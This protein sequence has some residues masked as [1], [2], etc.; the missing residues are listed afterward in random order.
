MENQTV[1]S[2]FLLLG[3]STIPNVKY[4]LFAIFLISYI[5]TLA[6]NSMVI[7]TVL[8]SHQLHSP[9]YFFLCNLSLSEILFITNIIPKMLFVTLKE[10]DSVSVPEC[11][12]QLLIMSALTNTECS[13]LTVMS[14]DRFLAICKP[15]HYTSIMN[16]K[17]QLNLALWSWILSFIAT[18]CVV[19]QIYFLQFC[20]PSEFDHYYCDFAPI[21][22]HSCSD[23]SIL[24]MEAFL[25]SAPI[26]LFP[27]IFI[28]KVFSTCSSHMAVVSMY[29]GSLVAIYVVPSVGHIWNINKILSLLYTVVTPLLNPIIYSI[30]NQEIRMALAKFLFNRKFV[31]T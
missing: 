6:G 9:M 31:D 24:E 27:F 23:T 16:W 14:Y 29:Y 13:I 4:V 25:F 28:I 22:K 5:V 8:N 15:L 20:G 17:L 3:F 21:I 18:L 2:E 7:A 19:L 10:G 30:R 1:I 12:S 11:I 26:T